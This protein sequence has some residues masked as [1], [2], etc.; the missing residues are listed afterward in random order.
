VSTYYPPGARPAVT[1]RPAGPAATGP[2]LAAAAVGSG[3]VAAVISVPTS[4]GAQLW[5]AVDVARP[6]RVV[7]VGL[8]AVTVC[9]SPTYADDGEILNAGDIFEAV[10]SQTGYGFVGSGVG[11]VAVTQ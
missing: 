1:G 8:V 9:S 7:N 6:V 10:T 11:A 4:P 3:N 5:L 2:P